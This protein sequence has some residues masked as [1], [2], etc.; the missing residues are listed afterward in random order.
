[1]WYGDA[2]AA[3]GFAKFYSRS[4]G[5]ELRV[6]DS[7]GAVIAVESWTGDFKEA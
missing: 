3:V 7:A 5:A 6:F 1:L 4:Q 2:E